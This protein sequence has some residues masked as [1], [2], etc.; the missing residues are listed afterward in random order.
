MASLIA[1]GRIRRVVFVNADGQ[2]VPKGTPGAVEKVWTNKK[3]YVG[4]RVNGKYRRVPAFRDRAASQ[5][6]LAEIV[7]RL[8]REEAGMAPDPFAQHAARPLGDHLEE[9]VRSVEARPGNPKYKG[10][11]VRI[12]RKALNGLSSLREL[13]SEWMFGYLEGLRTAPNTRKKCHSAVQMFCKWLFQQRRIPEQV[14][15]RVPIPRGGVQRRFR[16]LGLEEVRSL[17][18]SA[19][20]RRLEEATS[21]KGHPMRASEDVIA[22]RTLE[23]RERHLLYMTAITTGLRKEELSRLRVGHLNPLARPFPTVEVPAENTKGRRGATLLLIPSLARELAAWVSERGLTENDFIF[24]VGRHLHVTFRNDCRHAGIPL[25]TVKGL[26]RFR[27][28][29]KSSNVLLRLAGVPL[30]ERQ[31]FMRHTDIRLTSDT[32]DDLSLEELTSIVPAF[33]GLFGDGT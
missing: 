26:T 12:L 4:Y 33:E 31:L 3:Y 1:P 20:T 24:K 18:R 21:R 19:R 2:R 11:S 15:A 16:S 8:E 13:T 25:E 5:V 22:A 28:L 32:Y 30:K 29:R 23:G 9:Y 14:A 27:S 6:R 7:R 17:L 10:E